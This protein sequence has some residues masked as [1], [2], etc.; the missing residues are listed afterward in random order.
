ML[1]L[2]IGLFF[3]WAI[4]EALEDEGLN[5]FVVPVG[6]LIII[7]IIAA[8]AGVVAAILPAWRASKLNILDAIA[9]D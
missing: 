8:L 7:V 6:Q 5:A 1:G 2:A 3:G 4:V 9:D